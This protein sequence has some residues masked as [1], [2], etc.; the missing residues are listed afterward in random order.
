MLLFL[1]A[2]IA[3][4]GLWALKDKQS[5][6]QPNWSVC[7]EKYDKLYITKAYPWTSEYDRNTHYPETSFVGFEV[8]LLTPI[9]C[10]G[11]PI[12]QVRVS[13]EKMGAIQLMFP[14]SH[15]QKHTYVINR[16]KF[17]TRD[18]GSVVYL[19]GAISVDLER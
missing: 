12:D 13:Y 1:L 3:G 10:N 7:Q 4:I 18:G 14:A 15:Y 8:E 5:N 6:G 16:P 11:R 17:F 2:W 19:M 9:Q